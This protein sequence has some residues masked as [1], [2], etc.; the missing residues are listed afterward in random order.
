MGY[1]P[2]KCIRCACITNNR[3]VLFDTKDA[4]LAMTDILA[5]D[6]TAFVNEEP[7]AP[8]QPTVEVEKN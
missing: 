1:F 3:Q 6:N 5:K 8:V 7:V 2:I 4:S